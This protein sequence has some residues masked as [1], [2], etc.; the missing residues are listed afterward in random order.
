MPMTTSAS[1]N[2]TDCDLIDLD[3]NPTKSNSEYFCASIRKNRILS[4]FIRVDEGIYVP[5]T[6]QTFLTVE[7]AYVHLVRF[8]GASVHLFN[9]DGVFGSIEM[10][11]EWWNGL[12][13]K[14]PT[15][16]FNPKYWAEKSADGIV[17]KTLT[18]NTPFA[19]FVRGK[20]DLDFPNPDTYNAAEHDKIWSELHEAKFTASKL[21]RDTLLATSGKFL[22]EFD[23]A[24]GRKKMK[25]RH[26]IVTWGGCFARDENNVE[27]FHGRNIM[28]QMLMN[29]RDA[30]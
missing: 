21:F 26:S 18:S 22:Y 24:G 13:E 25:G 28:G 17:A 27:R 19:K 2:T 1:G 29:L 3:S 12:Q 30:Y 11:M 20:F 14:K 15:I 6:K 7:A 10:F 23:R 4:N 5:S 9:K 16:S 8:R